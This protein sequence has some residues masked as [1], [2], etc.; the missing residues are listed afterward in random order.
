MASRLFVLLLLATSCR[1]APVA[2]PTPPAADVTVTYLGAATLDRVANPLAGGLS[3]WAWDPTTGDYAVISDDPSE[4]APARFYWLRVPLQHGQPGA[5]Q[6]LGETVLRGP[7]GQPFPLKGLDPEGLALWGTDAVLVSSEGVTSRGVPP[8]VGVFG[9]DGAWRAWLPL[10]EHFTAETHGKAQTRG[11]RENYGLEALSLC[12]DGRTLLAMNE[13]PLVQDLP[14][15]AEPQPLRVV[16]WDLGGNAPVLAGERVYRAEPVP[17]GI[18]VHGVTSLLCLDGGR[19]AL[20]LERSWALTLGFLVRLYLADFSTAEAVDDAAPLA[21]QRPASKRLLV[22]LGTLGVRMDNFEGLALGPPLP[23]GGRALLVISDD[24]F[25]PF[26]VTEVL[27][28]ALGGV[29]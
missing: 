17:A 22:D 18:Q 27:V 3:D 10:P 24:N 20:V 28:F 2:R 21:A 9:R 13:A 7:D 5:P 1:T 23:G 15:P 8:F 25:M 26:Q 4:H 16:R 6:V 19:R 12:P 11:V 29:D 14:A